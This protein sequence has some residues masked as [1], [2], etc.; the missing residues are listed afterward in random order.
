MMEELRDERSRAELWRAAVKVP[1]YTVAFTP[2]LVGSAS[3]YADTGRFS[4][5]TLVLFLTAAIC[6]IAWLNLTNDVF[7]FDTG[8][9][10]NKAESV[11]NL[12]GGDKRSRAQVFRIANSFLIVGFAS[13]LGLSFVPVFDPAVLI[14]MGFAVFGGYSYQGPPFRLGYLGLGEPICF[15]TWFMSV[16]AAYYSQLRLDPISARRLRSYGEGTGSTLSSFILLFENLSRP[17]EYTILAAGLLVATP[18]ALI[19]LCSHFHQLEDDKAA[20]KRSPI[21]RLGTERAS[22]VVCYCLL[23]MYT[24]QVY[25]W[26]VGMLPRLAAVLTLLTA[27]KAYELAKFVRAFHDKP[28]RV[29]VAKYFAVRLHFLHGVALTLGYALTR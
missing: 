26:S 4:F 17:R 22:F 2:I 21:V 6:I 20:G 10:G 11:V 14:I 9:D 23:G 28:K 18:T 5:L 3:A 19:L 27:S 16:V 13:L 1:M 24:F 29:R 7:D 8:I 15:T 25:A 12:C